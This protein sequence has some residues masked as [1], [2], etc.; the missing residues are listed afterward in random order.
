[1]IR[2]KYLHDYHSDINKFYS[3]N[4]LVCLQNA[5]S[6]NHSF[7]FRSLNIKQ[8]KTFWLLNDFSAVKSV[9]IDIKASHTSPE[10]DFAMGQ[11]YIKYEQNIRRICQFPVKKLMIKVAEPGLILDRIVLNHITSCLKKLPKAE[12]IEIQFP[13]NQAICDQVIKK[14]IRAL[15]KVKIRNIMFSYSNLS[16]P[17][18]SWSNKKLLALKCIEARSISLGR[19]IGSFEPL[20]WHK[21]SLQAP[22]LETI[23]NPRR[24]TPHIRDRFYQGIEKFTLHSFIVTQETLALLKRGL[25]SLPRLKKLEISVETSSFPEYSIGDSLMFP[26]SL[27]RYRLIVDKADNLVALDRTLDFWIGKPHSGI[28]QLEI[29]LDQKSFF[30]NPI[31]VSDFKDAIL[32]THKLNF[33]NLRVLQIRVACNLPIRIDSLQHFTKLKV[34]KLSL[35]GCVVCGKDGYY[36]NSFL[37]ASIVTASME[38]IFDQTNAN[39]F[40]T[41]ILPLAVHEENYYQNLQDLTLIKSK[42]EEKNWKYFYLA[43][44]QELRLEACELNLTALRLFL[45]S[46]RVCS[47]SVLSLADS[48][49]PGQESYTQVLIAIISESMAA[50]NLEE[51]N[52]KG[53]KLTEE[54]YVNNESPNFGGL[55]NLRVLCLNDNP[56]LKRKGLA[57]FFKFNFYRIMDLGVSDVGINFADLKD[58]CYENAKILTCLKTLRIKLPVD[59]HMSLDTAEFFNRYF[60][61]IDPD[62]LPNNECSFSKRLKRL[63]T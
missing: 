33:P 21:I 51:L 43:S 30:H 7:F 16:A 39:E 58:I 36:S 35:N 29:N 27:K 13:G 23:P 18:I 59:S 25:E 55:P 8:V 4:Q 22:F 5:S 17:T 14:F 24:T 37:P 11:G 61:K 54:F 38:H 52:L 56:S 3:I 49:F 53:L 40:F 46:D 20:P 45:N 31:Q 44:L 15:S 2:R 57:E 34:L 28:Q 47:L 1:M 48:T 12:S 6:T 42:L 19:R 32:L 50:K 10:T 9:T 41:E 26:A 63:L 60:K 62:Q